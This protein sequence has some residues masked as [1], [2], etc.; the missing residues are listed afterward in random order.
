MSNQLRLSKCLFLAIVVIFSAV[1]W[2]EIP[3]K[4]AFAGIALALAAGIIINV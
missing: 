1:V 3:G 2:R 4:L